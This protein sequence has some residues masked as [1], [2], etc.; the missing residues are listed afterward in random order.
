VKYGSVWNESGGEHR[1]L[2]VIR[3]G[4]L[5][6]PQKRNLLAPIS[7]EEKYN[8]EPRQK[9]HAARV[10]RQRE[11]HGKHCAVSLRQN[12]PSPHVSTLNGSKT[13]KQIS[14]SAIVLGPHKE[15]I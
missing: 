8:S 14:A 5:E 2:L 3:W 13:N 6:N 9:R 10:Q 15:F 1:K 11:K 7:R 12:V 4:R